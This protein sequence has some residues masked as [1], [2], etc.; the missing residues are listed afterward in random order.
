MHDSRLDVV[1][2]KRA[3]IPQEV[4][5]TQ[6]NLLSQSVEHLVNLEVVV[7]DGGVCG[8]VPHGDPSSNMCLY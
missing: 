4:R 6:L 3:G 8:E 1:Q 5:V 7:Q 2:H